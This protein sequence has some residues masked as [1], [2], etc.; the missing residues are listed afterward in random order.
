M[1]AAR[2]GLNK[3]AGRLPPGLYVIWKM[4]WNRIGRRLSDGLQMRSHD[5]NTRTNG[6]HVI[7][8]E[9][10]TLDDA[11]KV[12]DKQNRSRKAAETQRERAGWRQELIGYNLFK[13]KSPYSKKKAT[14]LIAHQEAVSEA[15][16]LLV[17]QIK[18]AIEVLKI[19]VEEVS[20]FAAMRP[21]FPGINQSKLINVIID[22]CHMIGEDSPNFSVE[23][24]PGQRSQRQCKDCATLLLPSEIEYCVGCQ[25]INEAVREASKYR[26]EIETEARLLGQVIR[27]VER[28]AND[29]EQH[30]GHSGEDAGGLEAARREENLGERSTSS[31]QSGESDLGD[32]EGRDRGGS[33]DPG[34]DTVGVDYVAADEC[35]RNK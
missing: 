35:E 17:A 16:E 30:G 5:N 24:K 25:P 18:R 32:P 6:V 15:E 27:K 2:R 22:L 29:S 1:A 8:T 21:R 33:L 9:V 3:P 31:H 23:R 28:K 12:I 20:V 26:Y 14:D 19:A 11:L 34:K 10:A 7:R 4:G 13:R